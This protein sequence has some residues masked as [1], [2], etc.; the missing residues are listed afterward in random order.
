MTS[1]PSSPGV[2]RSSRIVFQQMMQVISVSSG[3]RSSFIVPGP[4]QNSLK[5]TYVT[6]AALEM[7]NLINLSCRQC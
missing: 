7:G 4:T 5:L 3:L 2:L 1:L 6:V